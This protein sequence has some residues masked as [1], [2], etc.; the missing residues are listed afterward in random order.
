MMTTKKLNIVAVALAVIVGAFYLYAPIINSSLT[1]KMITHLVKVGIKTVGTVV[2]KELSVKNAI[3]RD[4]KEK[5]TIKFRIGSI[6]Q[7]NEYGAIYYQFRD[8]YGKLRQGKDSV[9]KELYDA[10]KKNYFISILYFKNAPFINKIEANVAKYRSRIKPAKYPEKIEKEVNDALLLLKK[11]PGN[12]TIREK[13]ARLYMDTDRYVDCIRE[14]SSLNRQNP[15]NAHFFENLGYCYVQK[16]DYNQGLSSYHK[17]TELDPS[18]PSFFENLGATYVKLSNWR[19]AVV[20][21]KKAPS[22]F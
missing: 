9:D 14:Y 17:A 10:Y 2:N 8:Q 16:G 7:T 1:D 6:H 13:L 22:D 20:A 3:E 11:D 4:R 15:S 18:N 5:F 21:Y 19:E 12:V